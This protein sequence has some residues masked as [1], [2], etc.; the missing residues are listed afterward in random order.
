MKKEIIENL[1]RKYG[2]SKKVILLMLA[3]AKIIGYNEN[4]FKKLLAEFYN[5]H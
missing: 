2:K 4:D 3:N 1:C 5:K